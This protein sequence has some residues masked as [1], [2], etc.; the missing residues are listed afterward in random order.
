MIERHIEVTSRNGDIPSFAACPDAPGAYPGIILYMDAPGIREELVNLARRIAKHGYFCLLPDLYYRLGTLRFEMTRR[1]EG[2]M[3]TIFAA[4]NSLTNAMIVEDTA[5]LIGY[6]DAQEKVKPGALGCIGYCMSGKFVT[7]VAARYANRFAASASLYGV[8]IVTKEEDS[9]HLLVKAIKGEMYFGFAE[10]DQH[11]P[12]EVI[13]TL[14]DALNKAGTHHT[15][16]VLPGSHHGYQF[17][18][19]EV[20]DT[21]AAEDSWA[22]IFAMW[23]QRLK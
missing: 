19:R 3:Q 1:A 14:R 10:H 9:P 16:E 22:K 5:A 12:A 21:H 20:Y 7:T 11:V 8:G 23:E 15:L 6:L 13:P 18:E 2:R 4:M 17:P